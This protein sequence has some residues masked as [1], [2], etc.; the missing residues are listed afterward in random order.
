MYG[1]VLVSPARWGLLRRFIGVAL[2]SV[3]CLGTVAIPGVWAATYHVNDD[4]G[5][6][7]RTSA[8]AQNP[9]TP[10]KTISHAVGEPT[11]VPGDVI[12]VAAGTYNAALG[13]SFPL[14][15]VDGVAI[16]GA[17]PAVTTVSG[18][19]ATVLFRNANTPLA[20]GTT[21]SGLTLT[22]DA[23]NIAN[24][25]MSFTLASVAMAPEISGNSFV[26]L[27]VNDHGIEITDSAAGAQVV[28]R[29][30]RRQQLQR[31]VESREGTV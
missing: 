5:D 10:W 12:S 26:G 29:N 24:A 17:G 13:E 4:T 1:R 31:S 14:T 23:A 20:S 30:H 9:A 8:Q 3:L 11:L 22:H 16:I 27:A 25:G 28:H 7:A 15:M 2:A 19:A 18:P 21:L 6:D